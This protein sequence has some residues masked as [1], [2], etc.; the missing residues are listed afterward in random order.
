MAEIFGTPNDDT[1]TEAL[2]S[3]GVSGGAPSSDGD[4]IVGQG[5][6]DTIEGALGDDTVVGDVL[7]AG[8]TWTYPPRRALARMA[9]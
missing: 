9:L 2:V 8:L 3:D 5:G 6:S 4:V 1:I 7:A